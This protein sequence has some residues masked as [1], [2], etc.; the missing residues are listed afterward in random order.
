MNY[1]ASLD[2]FDL[3]RYEEKI[4]ICGFDPYSIK[5]SE[6]ST[7]LSL[8][9]NITEVDRLDYFIY[10]TNFFDKQS[11]KCLNSLEAHNFFT[12]GHVYPPQMKEI[13]RD[14]ILI[15]GKV[16][17]FTIDYF[18]SIHSRFSYLV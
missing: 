12:S 18:K 13:S 8:L 9:P 15:L 11:M 16:L 5:E 3:Q 17:C 14:V 1:K 7:D 10:N 4:K 6:Y 2:N